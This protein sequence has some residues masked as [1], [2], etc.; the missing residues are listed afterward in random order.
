MRD[1]PIKAKRRMNQDDVDLTVVAMDDQVIHTCIRFKID[2]KELF[3]PLSM[4]IIVIHKGGHFGVIWFFISIMFG[5]VLGVCLEWLR[6]GDSN[7]AY[8]HKVVKSRK[9]RSRIDSICDGNGVQ[10][11]EDQVPN[12]FVSYFTSF[13]GQEGPTLPLDDSDLFTSTLDHNVALYMVRDVMARE[14]KDAIF[15]N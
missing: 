15:A 12:A 3:A 4:L 8:F 10:L 11:V 5:I 13:L 9:A 6:V 1:R 14:V 7:S 2:K